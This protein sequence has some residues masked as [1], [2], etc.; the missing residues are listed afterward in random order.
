MPMKRVLLTATSYPRSTADWQ[1]VFIRRM[2]EGLTGKPDIELRVWAPDGPLPAGAQSSCSTADTHFLT[3]LSTEGGIAHLLRDAPV[4][5]SFRAAELLWRLRAGFVR[6]A[7]WAD[8]FHVNWLQCTLAMAGV[9]K[10]VLTTVLGTDLALLERPAVRAAVVRSLMGRRA[11]VCPNADWM[12]PILQDRLQRAD[13]IIEC[14]PFGIDDTWFAVRNAPRPGPNIWLVVLRLTRAKIGPLFEWTR[15]I[16]PERHRFHFFG[17]RQEEIDV[18]PWIYYHGAATPEALAQ[19]WFPLATGL[20][21]LSTHTEGRPQVL[22]E[23]M[24][25]GLPVICSRN[26]AHTDLVTHAGTGLLVSTP[27]EFLQA[28]TDASDPATRARLGN[29]A[30]RMVKESFGTWAD[31]ASRYTA[32]YDRLLAEA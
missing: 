10:P 20:I 8:I 24:A 31:C 7:A 18:P 13:C 2:A 32:I 29:K 9:R 25:A 19:D 3:R 11:A 5:G 26:A 28:L 15:D 23:A 21:S 22:L 27:E 14:V 17:P 16:D 12:V 6:N 30:R 4:R 1:G